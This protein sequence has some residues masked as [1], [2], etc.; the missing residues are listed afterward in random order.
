ME[1]SLRIQDLN[2]NFVFIN[3]VVTS[4]SHQGRDNV[5]DR[6]S[7]FLEYRISPHSATYGIPNETSKPGSQV[8][9]EPFWWFSPIVY[10][11][12]II[13]SLDDIPSP[14]RLAVTN[15]SLTIFIKLINISS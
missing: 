7:S 10:S 14:L 6:G 5:S 9:W 2:M 12:E 4:Y 8:L 13:L 1:L 15:K 11:L 3:K